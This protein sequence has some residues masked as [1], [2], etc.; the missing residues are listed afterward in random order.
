[1]EWT[2]ISF[3]NAWKWKLKVK[4]LIRV[5]LLGTPWTTAHQA[6]PSMRFS[7]QEYWSGVPLCGLHERNPK[8][9]HSYHFSGIRSLP[10]HLPNISSSKKLRISLYILQ[11]LQNLQKVKHFVHKLSVTSERLFYLQPNELSWHFIDIII[12]RNI[13]LDKWWVMIITKIG[14]IKR[15][16]DY[17]FGFN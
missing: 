6:P 10:I 11:E 1:M 13:L 15:R 9:Y 16:I 4:L 7:R 2:A 17:N 5:Q 14:K 8:E 3:S 12:K